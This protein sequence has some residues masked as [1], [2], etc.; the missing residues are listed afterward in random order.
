MWNLYIFR[1]YFPLCIPMLVLTFPVTFKTHLEPLEAVL[2]PDLENNFLCLILSGDRGGLQKYMWFCKLQPVLHV[3]HEN[4]VLNPGLSVQRIATDLEIFIWT[5]KSP[6]R[7]QIFGVSLYYLVTLKSY[8]TKPCCV[9]SL[10]QYI[11]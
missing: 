3:Q 7:K 6:C 10:G 1:K 8:N 4:K 2:Q 5:S 9:G 11:L